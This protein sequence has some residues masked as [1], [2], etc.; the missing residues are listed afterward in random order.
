MKT[1]PI[2]LAH[3]I[4]RF[5]AVREHFVGKLDNADEVPDRLHYFRGIKTHLNGSGF[6]VFHA[7]VE[8]AAGV[9]TRAEGLRADIEEVLKTTGQPKVHV[10]AHSM[11]GLDA[12]HMIVDLG[13]DERVCSLTTIGTPHNGSS[14][15]D[16]GVEHQADEAVKKFHDLV[17]LDGF[18]DLTT[19]ACRKF[20]ERAEAA[21]GDN[22][23]ALYQTFAAHEEERARVFGLLQLSW[24]KVTKAEG[25]NDGLVSVASQRWREE[26]R[27]KSRTK[28]VVR[29]T[30]P[31]FA[32]HLNECGWW[33][34][35]QLKGKAKTS[36]FK[37]PIKFFKRLFDEPREYENRVKG[38]YLDIAKDLA[39][40][41]PA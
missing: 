16:W 6:R 31:V 11:G 1:F 34:L 23:V 10:I 41:F 5:D 13:M 14:F 25:L 26:L 21:E 7:S 39:A 28:K 37:N 40:R 20:N 3:G 29:K 30:F 8:F 33:E 19:A 12:R 32:D 22:K 24:D 38:V 4:A 27:G 9:G 15:A 2:V 35:H 17:N 36:F 18:L